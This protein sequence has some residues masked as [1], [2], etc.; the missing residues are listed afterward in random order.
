M[1][2]FSAGFELQKSSKVKGP[3]DYEREPKIDFLVKPKFED[4]SDVSLIMDDDSLFRGRMSK[5]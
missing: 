3:I 2:A 1:N 5:L 4:H